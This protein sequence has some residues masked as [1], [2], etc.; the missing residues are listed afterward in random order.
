VP[1][2]F[3]VF[4]VSFAA[5][6]FHTGVETSFTQKGDE[7]MPQ[8]AIEKLDGKNAADTSVVDEMKTLAERIRQRAFE[9]F[10][11]R[12]AAD[13]LAIN[14]WLSA[15][16]DLFR[17]PESELVEREGKFEARVS[18]PGIDPSDVTV[19]AL[20]DALIVQ[21]SAVHTHEH[22]DGDV[23]F[24]EFDQRT[25]FRRFDLPERINVDQVTA[26]LDKGVL[27]L[28]AR[29]SVQQSGSGKNLRAA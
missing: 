13:G 16:R 24:C 21:G 3:F 26:N 22:S 7:L 12:G 27:Q 17:I 9:I 6:L 29:K 25:L 1:P 23:R 8:V 10:E 11:K 5:S 20:P 4:A 15:E 28:T 19:T 14:D 18:A 2:H